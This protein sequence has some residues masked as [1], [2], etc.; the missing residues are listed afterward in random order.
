MAASSSTSSRR[1][2]TTSA[3]ASGG[4]S[5]AGGCIVVRAAP[6]P[7]WPKRSTPKSGDGPTT[8]GASTARSWS[9]F[10]DGSTNT[11]SDGRDGNTSGCAAPPP[12]RKGSW[13]PSTDASPAC[14]PTGGSARAPK[15]GRWE[16]DELRG[17]RPVLRAP[18]GAIPPATH[19]VVGSAPI[20]TI[21]S[22]TTHRWDRASTWV[23]RRVG[24]ASEPRPEPCPE[25]RNSDPIRGHSDELRGPENIEKSL[26]RSHS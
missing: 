18:G 8:T 9:G 23:P 6:S 26:Q 3:N 10:S 17:S 21:T 5:A 12:R 2:A 16:P 13:P 14:S 11:S 7:T 19:P 24:G 25:P 20:F 4:S 15:A 22:A 1:S